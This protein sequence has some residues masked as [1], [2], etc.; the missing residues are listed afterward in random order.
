M[1]APPVDV[2]DAAPG[3]TLALAK[4]T[5]PSLRASAAPGLVWNAPGSTRITDQPSRLAADEDH[6]DRD[7]TR[8]RR[9][10]LRLRRAHRARPHRRGADGHRRGES[11]GSRSRGARRPRPLRRAARRAGSREDRALVER[12]RPRHLLVDRAGDHERRRRDRH[13]AVGSQGQAARRPRLRPAR[14]AHARARARLPPPGGKHRGR[15]GRG[16]P[17][18]AEQGFTALRFGPLAALD[19]HSLA[20]WDPQESI[21][22]T[23]EATES[24]RSAVGDEVDLLLDAH[25]M[26]SPAEA[27]YLGHALEPYRLYFYED[28]IR[29]LNPLSLRNGPRQGEPA[30]RDGRAARAQV[31]VPAADRERAGRLPAHRPG[32]RRRHHGGEEDP[33]R[34]RDARAALRPPPRAA[35]R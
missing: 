28:P 24:L 22:R 12:A 4:A 25:T 21:V 9:R 1:P 32:A 2:P 8:E 15:A 17:P 11:R 26:F 16:R 10:G 14:R 5:Q 30:D 20:H 33:R 31:G 7:P 3:T 35:R 29:P 18:L 34:R 6:R 27:A 23:I 19:E 13:R